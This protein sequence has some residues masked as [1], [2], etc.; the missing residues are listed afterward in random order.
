MLRM[1]RLAG[2]ISFLTL[3][4][5]SNSYADNN[6]VANVTPPVSNP[7]KSITVTQNAPQ[8]TITLSSNPTTGYSWY[9]SGYD[10]NLLNVV[11]HTYTS[12]ANT[13]L[14]G[15]GGTETWVFSVKPAAFSAP[16]ITT[17]NLIYARSWD[18]NYNNRKAAFT[19]VI[20]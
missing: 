15:A 5:C 18:V 3:L 4:F 10:S 6:G 11:S 14:I 8:F 9:L 2:F 17:I 20:H 16:H 1:I 7:Q 13:K 12:A 19:V